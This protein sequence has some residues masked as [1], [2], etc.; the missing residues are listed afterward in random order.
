MKQAIE[1]DGWTVSEGPS[2]VHKLLVKLVYREM[3]TVTNS[4][5]KFQQLDNLNCLLIDNV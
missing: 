2:S 1:L 4:A 5:T 3:D